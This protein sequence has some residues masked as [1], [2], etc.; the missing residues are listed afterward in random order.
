[1]DGEGDDAFELVEPEEMCYTNLLVSHPFLVHFFMCAFSIFCTVLSAQHTEMTPI[2]LESLLPDD[3]KWADDARM[4]YLM[5][6]AQM[7]FLTGTLY[8]SLI[9]EA[10]SLTDNDEMF[11]FAQN[12]N[13]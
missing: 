5:R 7:D 9:L 10:L 6:Q 3:N 4:H 11:D 2:G 8:L 1:M 12:R 13:L